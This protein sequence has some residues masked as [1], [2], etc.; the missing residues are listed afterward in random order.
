MAP[1]SPGNID[2]P[3]VAVSQIHSLARFI[4]ND[5]SGYEHLRLCAGI[6]LCFWRALSGCHV[7][8]CL[9]EL[10]KLFIGDRVPIHPKAIDG[11]LMRRRFFRIV[12]VGSHEKSAAGDPDHIFEWRLIRSWGFA[13]QQSGAYGIAHNFFL[14]GIFVNLAS[15]VSLREPIFGFFLPPRRYASKAKLFFTPFSPPPQQRGRKKG[16][17]SPIIPHR[18]PAR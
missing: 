7:L 13:L 2:P 12:L 16:G 4:E 14:S 15:L 9:D 11:H 18:A 5:R 10:A 3:V 8:G 6:I 17:R 1:V